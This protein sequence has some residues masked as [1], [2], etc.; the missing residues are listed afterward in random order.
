M[1]TFKVGDRIRIEA[2]VYEV[3]GSDPIL[4]KIMFKGGTTGNHMTLGEAEHAELTTSPDKLV[5]AVK[6]LLSLLVGTQASTSQ[7][8]EEV[9]HQ[10]YLLKSTK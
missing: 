10:L 6:T 7:A 1:K 8:Y 2:E 4:Y 3:I 9:L 5:D